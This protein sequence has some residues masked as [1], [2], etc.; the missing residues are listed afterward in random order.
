MTTKFGHET[1]L[2]DGLYA[3]FD[4][5]YVVLRALSDDRNYWITLEPSVLSAFIDYV[6]KIKAQ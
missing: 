2:G 4:G 1:H 3:S 6:E 5:W